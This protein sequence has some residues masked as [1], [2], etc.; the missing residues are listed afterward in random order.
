MNFTKETTRLLIGQAWRY[1]KFVIGLLIVT[2]LTVLVHQFLPPLIVATVLERLAS[3]K[4]TPGDVWNSFGSDLVTYALLVIGGAIIGWRIVIF[5]IWRLE[6]KVVGDIHRRVFSHLMRQSSDFHANHFGGSLVS[7]TNKLV[8]AY[9]TFFDTTI[10][11]VVTMISAF[12]FTAVILW[13]KAPLFVV[14]MLLLSVIFMVTAVLITKR[15]RTLNAAEAE[16]SNRQTGFLADAI[17]NV[18]AVRSF[19]G[20]QHEEKRYEGAIDT[21]RQAE[22]RL[23]TATLRQQTYFATFTTVLGISALVMGVVGVVALGADVATMFLIISFTSNI[24]QRLWDFSQHTLR[25]YNRALGDA[26]AMVEILNEEPSVKDVAKP[27]KSRIKA[28]AIGFEQVTFTHADAKADDSLFKD[29]DLH[30]KA[31]TKIGLV[32]HSGSGKTTLTKLLLR[33]A[34]I[35]GGTITVDGQ[36]I[37]KLTQDD[38]R[39]SIAYV[40]QEPLLFHRSLRENIAYGK[41]DATDEEVREAARRAHAAEFIEKLPDGY[42]TEVGERGVKLSGGQRQRIAIA[43]AMLK[44]APILVLDEATSALDSESERLIQAALW[45]LMKGRT[46]IVIAHRLST[47]QRM[48]EIVVL[49]NGAIL[50]KGSHQDLLKQNGIYASLWNHQSGGFIEE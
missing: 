46:A 21:W 19:A 5:L 50:E 14:F 31:G 33:F 49:D 28:G 3:G 23:M 48:D 38:L 34:D 13:P 27:E 40:P 44:N 24:G 11:E 36:D 12:T 20:V 43:R 17:T 29:L 45:E 2:P 6:L 22:R 47:I 18:F 35:D 7:Q 4:F 39:R 15:I 42:D 1:P 26:K 10:F 32:G 41:P 25:N 16:A 30:I 9:I 37:S 8:S